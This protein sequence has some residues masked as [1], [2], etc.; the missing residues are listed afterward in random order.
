MTD[1]EN[2]KF[3]TK[4]WYVNDSESKGYYSHENPI[5]FLTGPLESILCDYCDSYILA[6]GNINVTGVD[7]NTKLAFKNS[8]PFRQ[9]RTNK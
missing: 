5:K 3:A 4:K 7:A 2:S 1:N 8:A 9:C 6:T